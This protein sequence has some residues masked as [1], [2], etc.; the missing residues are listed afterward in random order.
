MLAAYFRDPALNPLK[1]ML[2]WP[3]LADSVEKVGL[4]FHGRKIRI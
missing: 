4:G 2:Q 1:T 3:I